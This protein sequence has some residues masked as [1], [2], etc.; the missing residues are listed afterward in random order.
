MQ[1]LCRMCAPYLAPLHN[2][3]KPNIQTHFSLFRDMFTQL[4]QQG[5]GAC[6]P[7]KL[8]ERSIAPCRIA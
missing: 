4:A 1:I 8:E 2:Q 7:G 5:Q 3:R 6:V